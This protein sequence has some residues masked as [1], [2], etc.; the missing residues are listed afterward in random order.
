MNGKNCDFSLNNDNYP[1]KNLVHSFDDDI[2][3]CHLRVKAFLS[4]RCLVNLYKQ[5]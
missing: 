3:F 2:F 1:I 4:R 5:K